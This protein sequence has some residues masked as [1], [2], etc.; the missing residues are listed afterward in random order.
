MAK[1]IVTGESS[2][3]S[4]LRGVNILAD[5]VKITL[6]P[7]GRNAVIEKKF[8][9]PVITKDGVTV[10]KEIELP[11]PLENM[12]AQMV[13]EVASKTSDVAGDGTTTATVLAQAIFRE[14]VKT[15]AAGAS[16]MALK[17]GIERAV[18]V[19]VEEV[20]KLHKDVKGD[21][22]AQV[23]TISANNDKQ[24]GS[25]IAEAMKK[26][27]KDGVITVEESKTMETTL[28]VVEGM[29][30][31][32]GYLSPYFVTDPERMECG[33]E[34]V[35]ILIHEKKISSMKD[36]LPLLEQIAKMSKPLLIIAEDVEGEA[37]ATLV[38]NKLR[39]T[40][41]CAAVKAPGFGD[42]RKAMLED[43]ATLT[44]GKAITE[45]L[46]IKLENVK[47]EDLGRAKKITIDKDNTTIVEGA[48][49]ASE[50]EGRV[51]Q[52]RTQID[53]TTS[54]YDREKLQERLA[55][56]VGGVA[57]IKVGAATETELKEKKARVEDAM[58]ATRAA[59][60]EGIVPGGG[61]ALVRCIAALEKLK[62]HDDEA[63]GVN[64]V[65]RALEEPM[66]QIA[67]NA[68]HEGAVVVGRVRDAKEDNFGLNADSGEYGDL[69]KAGVIDPAKVTRLALQNAA[70]IA[71]L[72]LTTE[73]LVA[74]IKEEEKKGAGAGGGMPG[75]G[76][77]GGM[78]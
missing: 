70:S 45:D 65:K 32:R 26:V 4:I 42:R 49:K 14:G 51:K 74:D 61:V 64:I 22:I 39:G 34:D 15:V 55:K 71:G 35:R 69:V 66:R 30:F 72:M 2:R 12:G 58:H 31:D 41:Q 1:Q 27:G 67:Y 6:G 68:G 29:Q 75:G 63:I 59:V 60:E 13:R 52:I 38:V 77:M 37:L 44:G 62:L 40:L 54:D 47:V 76:G 25:I 21:M 33:L 48:G 24:I 23:G 28:E 9:A 19:A 7:K 20:K 3:Q 57:V 46:G 78:Y 53:E 36:L 8:G 16:P 43:I 50:I 56:L 17:R 73:A 5:A 18:E 11:D 10:A